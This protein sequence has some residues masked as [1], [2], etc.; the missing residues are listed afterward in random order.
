[1]VPLVTAGP[2]CHPAWTQLKTLFEKGESKY[3]IFGKQ[4][5]GES[6]AGDA[7]DNWK[8]ISAKGFGRPPDW[9]FQPIL[10]VF[11]NVVFELA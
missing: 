4:L 10:H 6:R 8:T 5:P 7:A 1:M 3:E 9:R 11:W 2:G